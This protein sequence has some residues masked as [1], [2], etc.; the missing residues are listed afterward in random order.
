MPSEFTY[1][2]NF[3]TTAFSL[4]GTSLRGARAA[5][6]TGDGGRNVSNGQNCPKQMRVIRLISY[7]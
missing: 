3:T 5:R 4:S 1:V 2:T 7:I 6:V